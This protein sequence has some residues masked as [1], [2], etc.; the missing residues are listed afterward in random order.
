MNTSLDPRKKYLFAFAHPDDDVGIAGTMRLLLRR[1]ADIHC[2]WATSG[3]FFGQG[4]IR[5]SETYK[6]MEILGV[7][8]SNVHLLRF[9]DLSLVSRLNEAADA[10]TELLKSVRPD[11]IFADAY[12]GG[13]PDHDSVNFMVLEGSVR[14]GLTLDFFEFPLYNGSG[15]LLELGWK[16]N[17]FPAGG[18]D[19]LHNVLDEDAIETKYRMMRT[20][21]SQWMYMVPARLACSRLRLSGVGEPYRQFSGSRDHSVPPHEGRLGYERWF[22]AFM[23]TGFQDFRDAVIMARKSRHR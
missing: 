15:S 22:N 14:A 13:H 5:E 19:V 8:E 7:P 12:E 2:V 6:S 17:S 3:D 16:L 11:V 10:M 9:P 21:S 1:V 23:R 20:H 4:E 18:P